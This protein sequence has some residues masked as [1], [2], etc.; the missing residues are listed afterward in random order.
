MYLFQYIAKRITE[1]LEVIHS[2]NHYKD[3]KWLGSI[4]SITMLLAS[5]ASDNI[6]PSNSD[7]QQGSDAEEFYLTLSVTSPNEAKTKSY[8]DNDEEGDSSGKT[9]EGTTLESTLYSATIYFADEYNNL[10][11][12]FESDY[13]EPMDGPNTTI[14]IVMTERLGE[15]TSLVGQTAHIFI[16]GNADVFTPS[17]P[18]S[19]DLS[20][21]TFSTTSVKDDSDSPV[22]SFGTNG[23]TMPLMNATELTVRIPSKTGTQKTDEE[24]IKALFTRHTGTIAWW[25]INKGNPLD[26]ERG[27]A[28]LEY[29]DQPSTER[30]GINL[31]EDSHVYW[32]PTVGKTDHLQIQLYSLEPFNINSEAYLF[33]HTAKGDFQ[34]ADLDEITLFGKERDSENYEETGGY[35]WVASNWWTSPS[36]S[37]TPSLLHKLT[38]DLANS[39]YSIDKEGDALTLISKLVGCNTKYVPF[40]YVMENTLPSIELMDEFEEPEEDELPEDI[41]TKYATGVAFNF[42]VLDKNGDPLVYEETVATEPGEEPAES[43][44]PEGVTNSEDN[45]GN[46]VITDNEGMWVELSP[47]TITENGVTHKY[48]FLKYICCIVHNDGTQKYDDNSKYAP[49]YY[50]VVRN[51]TY[52]ISVNSIKGLPIPQEPRTLYISVDVNILS[53]AKRRQEYEL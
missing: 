52:Q 12:S 51:N 7:S 21:A 4:V 40:Y 24:A 5:C 31:P 37:P 32:V 8:T 49:M 23:K 14:R 50:G 29:K 38:I 1:K 53:W 28:R 22:G 13:V 9:L 35:S 41:V 18:N 6:E 43:K 45:V 2:R 42:L 30:D 34:K 3:W 11:A 19:K 27:V 17:I 36:A 26:L 39:K 48:F 20:E 46:I 44:Y 10:V 16:V 15:L 33:R 25:D 47:V